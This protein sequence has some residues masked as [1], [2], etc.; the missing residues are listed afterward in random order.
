MIKDILFVVVMLQFMHC[1]HSGYRGP[2]PVHID[3]KVTEK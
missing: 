1:S 3:F 2:V